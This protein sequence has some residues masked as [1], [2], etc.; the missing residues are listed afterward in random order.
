MLA[1]SEISPEKIEAYRVTDY[2]VGLDERA[3]TLRIDTRSQALSRLYKTTGQT[4]AVFITAFNPYGRA[5]CEE[6]NESAH[7]RLR[8]SLHGI[9]SEVIEGAGAHPSG[10]WPAEK[11]FFALGVSEDTARLLGKEFHQDAVVWAGPEAIPR[12]LLLR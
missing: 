2:R 3:F 4:C 10:A 5:Q 11:S 1:Q 9:A 6:A 12:L 7:A 8:N